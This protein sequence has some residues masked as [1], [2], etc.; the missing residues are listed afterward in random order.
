MKATW[1]GENWRRKTSSSI[2]E[3]IRS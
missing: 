2:W 3:P 1:L